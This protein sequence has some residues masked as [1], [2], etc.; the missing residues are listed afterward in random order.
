MAI[1]IGLC[2]GKGLTAATG[3]SSRRNS[4]AE[5]EQQAL[6]VSSFT[7][8]GSQLPEIAR[9]VGNRCVNCFNLDDHKVVGHGAGSM[10]EQIR[11][12]VDNV[13]ARQERVTTLVYLSIQNEA[14]L[15]WH[16]PNAAQLV[17]EL[18]SVDSLAKL[19]MNLSGN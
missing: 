11:H 19:G 6:P 17:V 12:P 13:F 14:P 1:S 3:N 5:E 18:V 10:N 7:A 15:L 8:E 16:R 4:V 9:N 2:L